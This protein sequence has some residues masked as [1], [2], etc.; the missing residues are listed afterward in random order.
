MSCIFMSCNFRFCNFRFCNFMPCKFGLSFSCPA[1]SCPANA[2]QI[3]PSFSCPAFSY[4][5][6]LMVR[7]FH[8]RHFQSTPREH[9]VERKPSRIV[10]FY[11]WLSWL[12]VEIAIVNKKKLLKNF[13]S[14][15]WSRPR[16]PVSGPW[17]GLP[18][19]SN[20]LVLGHIAVLQKF[21]KIRSSI[22]DHCRVKSTYRSPIFSFL[23][24]TQKY[25]AHVFVLNKLNGLQHFEKV[26]F[27]FEQY[28]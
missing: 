3:G 26:F 13:G 11:S 12:S 19:K 20:R 7:H 14:V 2:L 4:P 16:N 1:I 8:V 6:I 21:T 15:S 27:C 25:L 28:F 17:S 5:A 24:A 9:S 23:N 10:L 18:P 22:F